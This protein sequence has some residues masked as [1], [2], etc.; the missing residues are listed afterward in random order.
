VSQDGV[1]E[2]E[3]SMRITIDTLHT[4]HKR[5][6]PRIL[7]TCTETIRILS[8]FALRCVDVRGTNSTDRTNTLY[9]TRH[10]YYIFL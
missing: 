5:R 2:R 6:L 7:N 9:F 10:P 1:T 3:K 8:K 4:R